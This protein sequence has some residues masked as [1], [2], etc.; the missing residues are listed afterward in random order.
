MN[1]FSGL[2]KY[3]IFNFF[4]LLERWVACFDIREMWILYIPIAVRTGNVMKGLFFPIGLGRN[5]YHFMAAM[6]KKCELYI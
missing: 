6:E 1:P 5:R 4:L 3:V 2:S